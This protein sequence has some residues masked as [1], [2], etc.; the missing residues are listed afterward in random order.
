MINLIENNVANIAINGAVNAESIRIN[1]GSILTIL[2]EGSINGPLDILFGE[3]VMH[4]DADAVLNNCT[5]EVA[6]DQLQITQLE[7]ALVELV[8]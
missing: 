8:I 1:P 6:G 2:A 3:N 7:G 5:I 4:L